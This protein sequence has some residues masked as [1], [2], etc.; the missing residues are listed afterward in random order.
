MSN[1]GLQRQNVTT[2]RL[3]K[4]KSTRENQFSTMISQNANIRKKNE[5]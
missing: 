4:L 5:D 3:K 2:Y 1:Y